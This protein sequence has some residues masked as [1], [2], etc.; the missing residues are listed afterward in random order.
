MFLLDMP[1]MP[2]PDRELA[3]LLLTVKAVDSS[4][5]VFLSGNVATACAVVRLGSVDLGAVER[6]LT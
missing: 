1:R 2:S 5:A 4:R 3:C 6:A